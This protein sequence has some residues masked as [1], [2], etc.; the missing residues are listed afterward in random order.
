MSEET[1]GNEAWGGDHPE[2]IENSTV[3][4]GEHIWNLGFETLELSGSSA[5]AKYFELEDY[6]S[7][8]VTRFK[9]AQLYFKEAL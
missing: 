9:D 3:G 2:I 7:D 4:F 8:G 1:Q 5:E 6:V